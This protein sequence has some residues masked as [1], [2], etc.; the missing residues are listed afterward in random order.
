M[1][2]KKQILIADDDREFAESLADILTEECGH[3]ITV[4]NGK[5]ALEYMKKYNIKVVLMDIKMSDMNGVETLKKI[6]EIKPDIHVILMTG[7]SMDELIDEAF[8][9]GASEVLIKPLDIAHVIC[10]I[11]RYLIYE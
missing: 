7:F 8:N 3:T 1:S 6:K 10:V 5:D 4:D 11:N 9:F 2:E